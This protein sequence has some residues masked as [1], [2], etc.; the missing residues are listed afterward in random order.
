MTDSSTLPELVRGLDQRGQRLAAR[1]EV[2][3]VVA[4]VLVIPAILIEARSTSPTLLTIGEVLDWLIWIV[5]AAEFFTLTA[6]AVN[7]RAY[8]R[9]AWLEII[10]VVLTFPPLS[11]VAETLEIAGLVRLTRLARLTRFGVVMSRLGVILTRIFTKRGLGYIAALTLVLAVSFGVIYGLVEDS[12][13]VPD[14]IWWAIV[15]LTTVGYGDFF[16]ATLAGRLLAGLLMLVGI[17]FVATLTATVA[18]YFVD[19]QEDDLR[20]DI[21]KMKADLAAASASLQRIEA[22]IAP[23]QSTI[24]T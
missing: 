15:T 17:G 8:L 16:P 2:P 3:V 18:A 13:S 9:T 12:A 23:E 20:A 5:F 4:A 1:F 10:V 7:R 11:A 24:D 14:G 22:A 6:V 21:D 19:E